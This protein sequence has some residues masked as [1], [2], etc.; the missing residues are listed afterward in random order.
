MMCPVY[1][2]P[3]PTVSVKTTVKTMTDVA[4]PATLIELNIPG[5]LKELLIKTADTNYKLTVQVDGE[6]LYDNDFNW[7]QNISQTVDEISAFQDETGSY[8]LHLADIKWST[9]IKVEA[10]PLTTTGTLKQVFYKIDLYI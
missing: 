10:Q 9:N 6:T 4:I 3:A 5:C 7:F 2:P 8:I 1:P